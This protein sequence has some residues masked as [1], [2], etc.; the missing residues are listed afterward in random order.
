MLVNYFAEH[1]TK[2]YGL[3]PKEISKELMDYMVSQDWRGNVRELNN[4]M[5][6]GIILAQDSDSIKIEHINNEMFSSV[7][8]NLS[9]ESMESEDLPLMS[10]EEAEM[11]LIRKA[12]EKTNGN[13]KKAAELLGISDR[14]I[15]N[16]LKQ[17]GEDE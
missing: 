16:K 11:K 2:H 5:H 8:E 13:Q 14:T 10:I 1:Y 4:K 3:E 17:Y 9:N 15:R 6:R 7:D 12:L